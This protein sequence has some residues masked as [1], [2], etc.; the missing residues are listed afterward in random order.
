[1][2]RLI[3]KYNKLITMEKSTLNLR[4]KA[5]VMKTMEKVQQL[6]REIP[7]FAKT[8][9][10][11]SIVLNERSIRKQRG[12]FSRTKSS[13]GRFDVN[14]SESSLKSCSTVSSLKNNSEDET[15]SEISDEN[16]SC[17]FSQK[18]DYRKLDTCYY[19]NFDQKSSASNQKSSTSS[20]S[21][22][23]TQPWEVSIEGSVPVSPVSSNKTEKKK[24]RRAG[25]KHRSNKSKNSDVSSKS[26]KEKV[27]YKTEICKNWLEKGKCNYSVR[28][29]FAHGEHEL[30]R[31]NEGNVSEDYKSKPCS[32]FHQHSYCSYGVRC[33]FIHEERQ[34]SDMPKSFFGKSLM[35]DEESKKVVTFKR[36]P[37]F[38]TLSDD[39]E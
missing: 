8:N 34:V 5:F 31:P 17:L 24:I 20:A 22:V 15:T 6:K 25:R 30:V 35:L 18:S 7:S 11:I 2:T 14:T 27:K 10:S 12:V 36:L 38:A 37:V 4:S 29:M 16:N 21:T 26:D 9:E 39:S 28:C 3:L 23:I 32:A 19:N 33:L 13:H 1:M